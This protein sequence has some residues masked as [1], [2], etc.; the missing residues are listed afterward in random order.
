MVREHV[1]YKNLGNCEIAHNTRQYHASLRNR[2]RFKHFLRHGLTAVLLTET[3]G[4]EPITQTLFHHM[5]DNYYDNDK[6]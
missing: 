1:C 5:C 4:H 3:L 6:I 2:Y